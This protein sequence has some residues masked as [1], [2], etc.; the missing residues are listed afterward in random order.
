MQEKPMCMIVSESPAMRVARNDP[1]I[2]YLVGFWGFCAVQ[3]RSQ[4]RCSKN[5]VPFITLR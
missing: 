3:E 1:C 5:R 4:A 2:M